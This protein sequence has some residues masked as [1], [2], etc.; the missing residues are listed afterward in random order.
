[1]VH[2]VFADKA[3]WQGRLVCRGKRVASLSSLNNKLGHKAGTASPSLAGIAGRFSPDFVLGA[4]QETWDLSTSKP[5]PRQ[6][7]W[8]IL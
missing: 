2:G 4:G 5:V 1:M 8:V 3:V 7:C 6:S